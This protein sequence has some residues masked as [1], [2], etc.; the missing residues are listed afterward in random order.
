MLSCVYFRIKKCKFEH[1]GRPHPDSLVLYPRL[2]RSIADPAG[3]WEMIP[4]V[5]AHRDEM[6]LAKERHQ[7]RCLA[8]TGR[9]DDEVEATT[10]K[11]QL[12]VHAEGEPALR[13]RERKCAVDV[14]IRP[15]KAGILKP[16]R[17]LIET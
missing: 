12:A 9:P 15:G 16:D 14:V 4:G 11:K 1:V 2:L 13:L 8:R 17:V 7:Q 3:S 6:H 10:L 5:V